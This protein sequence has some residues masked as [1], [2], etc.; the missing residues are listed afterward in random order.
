MAQG[1]TGTGTVEDGRGWKGMETWFN[2]VWMQFYRI[3]MGAEAMMVV[4]NDLIAN[5]HGSLGVW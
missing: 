5:F 4:N 1:S 3:W 2:V